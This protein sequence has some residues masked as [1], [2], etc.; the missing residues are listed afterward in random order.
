MSPLRSLHFAGARIGNF[1]SVLVGVDPSG[2]V[3]EGE[4]LP[5]RVKAGWGSILIRA[6][7]ADLFFWVTL[8]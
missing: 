7:H 2:T 6:R 3:A 4:G 1:N 8:L 5:V